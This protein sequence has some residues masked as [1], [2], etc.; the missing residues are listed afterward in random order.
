[1]GIISTNKGEIKLFYN[2]ES[3]L[4]KQIYAYV[5]ASDKKV[6]SIDTAKT[7]VPG[8]H[9]TEIAAKLNIPIKELINTQHPDFINIYGKKAIDLDEHDWLKILENNPITLVCP[10]VAVGDDFR[11][12]KTPSDF[13]GYLE[14]DSTGGKNP[15]M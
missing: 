6:L 8:S 12:I 2:S 14:L 11:L 5:T 13:I 10:I 4:G 3:S 9:W 7:K 15:L 1:M